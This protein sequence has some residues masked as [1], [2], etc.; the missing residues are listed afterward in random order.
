MTLSSSLFYLAPPSDSD[1]DI[2]VVQETKTMNASRLITHS[3]CYVSSDA[4]L[5][6]T[7]NV[8]ASRVEEASEREKAVD[9]NSSFLCAAKNQN[10]VASRYQRGIRRL[11]VGAKLIARKCQHLGVR[12]FGH[13]QEVELISRN[14][15][16]PRRKQPQRPGGEVCP[17]PGAVEYWSRIAPAALLFC[18]QYPYVAEL[19]ELYHRYGQERDRGHATCPAMARAAWRHFL[20]LIQKTMLTTLSKD[21]LSE[22]GPL[23]QRSLGVYLGTFHTSQTAGAFVRVLWEKLWQI[24]IVSRGTAPVICAGSKVRGVLSKPKPVRWSLSCLS[25]AVSKKKKG[26]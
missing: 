19:I 20:V 9:P 15:S 2:L 14:T 13:S 5:R 25:H 26:T 8:D 11:R 17:P 18:R 12:F 24:I 21:L 10:P 22:G 1:E 6:Q 23:L 16:S 3:P 7:K 4:R